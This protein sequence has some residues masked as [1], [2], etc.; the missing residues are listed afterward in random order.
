LKP[1][2]SPSGGSSEIAVNLERRVIVQK[3]LGLFDYRDEG[4]INGNW[5]R[6]HYQ[7]PLLLQQPSTLYFTSPLFTKSLRTITR[8]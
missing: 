5:L 2:R 3:G 6:F 4:Q 7:T 8:S 1:N